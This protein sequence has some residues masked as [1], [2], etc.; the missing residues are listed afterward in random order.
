MKEAIVIAA[1][2]R[3]LPLN[4]G[5]ENVSASQFVGDIFAQMDAERDSIMRELDGAAV[6]LLAAKK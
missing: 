2:F 4:V 6:P 5:I 3:A 1:E